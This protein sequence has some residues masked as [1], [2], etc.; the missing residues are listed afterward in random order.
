MEQRTKELEINAVVEEEAATPTSKPPPLLP[1]PDKKVKLKIVNPLKGDKPKVNS[2]AVCDC[3][4]D[5]GAQPHDN[6]I[7]RH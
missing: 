7:T 1:R 6:D 3:V 4:S 2:P 5:T